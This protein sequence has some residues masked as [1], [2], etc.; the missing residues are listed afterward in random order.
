MDL[1]KNIKTEGAP[2]FNGT[3]TIDAKLTAD[4][5][6]SFRGS[7]S[8]K[9]NPVTVTASA[10]KSETAQRIYSTALGTINSLSLDATV[11]FSEK[12]GVDMKI[13]T[14]FDKILSQALVKVANQEMGT[15][16]QE[17][18]AKLNDKLGDNE[19][20]NKYLTQFS[21]I[22]GKMSNSKKSLNSLSKTMEEKKAEL[23][24][25]TTEAAKEKA[26]QAANQAATSVLKKLKK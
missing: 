26:S 6:F 13:A 1:G 5:D 15:A 14:D 17:V 3:T 21:D 10:L 19:A 2:V 25:K 4:S 18:M 20:C 24:K 22:S 8:M 23:K 16:K 12:S 9:L 7:G 11:G